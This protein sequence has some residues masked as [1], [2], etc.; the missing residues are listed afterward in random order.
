MTKP[1]SVVL[2]SGLVRGLFFSWLFL[3]QILQAKAGPGD[4]DASF[5]PGSSPDFTI[6]SVALQA[7][8]KMIIGGEFGSPGCG[9]AR[10]NAN[11]SVDKSFNPGT[12]VNAYDYLVGLSHVYSVAVQPDGKILVAGTFAT[13]N[14]TALNVNA[15]ARLNADG[16]LDPGFNPGT[17]AEGPIAKI[18]SVALQ[19][20]G[21]VLVG[22]TFNSI[23]G[24]NRNGI[25]RLNSNGSL[26]T[27]F[28]PGTG[29]G[30]FP[31]TVYTVA[32]QTNGQ[33]LVAGFF[34][35]ING[36]NRNQIARLNG[37]G[38]VDAGFDPGTGPNNSILAM[39]VQPDG[40]VLIGGLF[41]TINGGS[42]NGIARL[43]YDGTLDTSFTATGA[44]VRSV[45]LQSDGKVV[46][47]GSFTIVNGMLR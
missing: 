17:G 36:T 7:D 46:I 32:S 31:P 34:S 24:T 42:H 8:G 13:F 21:K 1:T 26:D 15:I 33:V 14:G 25:A 45:A 2:G 44:N 11:G 40:K 43:N 22:G 6:F 27:S 16:S 23:N 9:V 19:A 12:G 5:D 35:S 37:N 30:G 10:L 47:G 28:D 38:S 4:V 29:A 41:T 18:Y 39:T 3:L 20:D